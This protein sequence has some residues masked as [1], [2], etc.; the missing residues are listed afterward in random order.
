MVGNGNR[1]DLAQLV[2]QETEC[3]HD[4]DNWNNLLTNCTRP[5]LALRKENDVNIKM[6]LHL[7][8][9]GRS[10]AVMPKWYMAEK[11][12]DYHLINLDM[13]GRQHKQ[14]DYLKINPFGK[15]PSLVD[16]S[17]GISLFESGAILLY[18]SEHYGQESANPK[19]RA[20][21]VQWIAF[22]NATLSPAIFLQ[23]VHERDF[24]GIMDVLNKFYEDK[25]YLVGERWTAADCAVCA[26]LA[27]VPIFAKETDLNRWPQVKRQTEE[28]LHN[29]HYK[30]IMS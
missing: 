23:T 11:Q 1:N 19:D 26:Y 2:I 10:R 30:A 24:E 18:L 17:T 29:A 25:N 15:L 14:P 8:G 9:G 12:I 5:R 7:Y 21:I 13:R 27:Y 28:T 22:A 20:L 16:D 6:T 4:A 3:Q